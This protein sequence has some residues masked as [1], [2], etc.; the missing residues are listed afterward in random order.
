MNVESHMANRRFC[1]DAVMDADADTNNAHRRPCVRGQTLLCVYGCLKGPC[2]IRKQRQEP[3]A[4]PVCNDA[5]SM[6][7]CLFKKAE[8]IIKYLLIGLPKT[9]EK[10]RRALDVG[11]KYPDRI[12]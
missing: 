1:D 7:N 10:A 5:I 3:I 4:H 12:V 6:S 8:M 2:R 9:L 11:E